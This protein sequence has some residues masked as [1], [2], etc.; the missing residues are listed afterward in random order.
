VNPFTGEKRL[1]QVHELLSE[2]PMDAPPPR[3]HT[4]VKPER[5]Y[6]WKVLVT[7]LEALMRLITDASDGVVA[8]MSRRALLGP[9]DAEEWVFEIP[10]VFVKA[11]AGLPLDRVPEIARAWQEKIGWQS[12]PRPLLEELVEVAAEAIG[13]KGHMFSYVSL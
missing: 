4:L 11:L 5:A 12:S 13:A 6:A 3:I 1:V 2:E 7:D 9:S 10:T 8:E